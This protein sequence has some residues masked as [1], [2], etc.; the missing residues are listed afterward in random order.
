MFRRRLVIAKR[1]L[2]YPAAYLTCI[3]PITVMRFITLKGD[4]LPQLVWIFGMFLLLSLAADAVIYAITR[5]MIRHHC[6]SAQ[7]ITPH[8]IWS[9][10]DID[11]SRAGI[12][13][14]WGLDMGVATRHA[15][16]SSD[17]V[18][19]D[20]D[21]PTTQRPKNIYISRDARRYGVSIALEPEQKAILMSLGRRV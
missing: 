8:D 6:V 18:L 14:D 11:L 5:H 20:T 9:I 17:E 21:E 15:A 1:M 12:Q 13:S 19:P 10:Y 16:A 2:W 3:L 4:D 7:V